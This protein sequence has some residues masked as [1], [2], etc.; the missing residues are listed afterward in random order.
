MFGTARPVLACLRD[1][2]RL[3]GLLPLY[4]L[5]E[6][7]HRKLLP[8]GVGISDHCDCLLEPGLPADAA[9][10][11]L[12]VALKAGR[13]AG[14]TVCDLVDVPAA[15]RLQQATPPAG[16]HG[17]WRQ[18]TPCPVLPVPAG[19]AD[20]AAAVPARQR[21][22]LRM[23][24]HRADRAGG[25]HV[26]YATPA[27]AP[28]LLDDLLRQ[29]ARRWHGVDP[30]VRR[31][32]CRPA[33]P[34]RDRPAAAGGAIRRGA[35]GRLCYAL[36]DRQERLMFY[37]MG[38][39]PAFAALSPGSLLLAAMIDDAIA[40]GCPEVHFLRGD[41]A[42]KYAWGAQDRHNPSCRLEAA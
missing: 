22:K 14:A 18:D 38:F 7:G 11:L 3:A 6:N 33:A 32:R 34:A 28:T 17:E 19:A 29:H 41:E 9:R 12:A 5:D 23:N 4:V 21:R 31:F 36:S 37:M 35:A 8:L 13:S 27:T 2:D 26:E 25:W 15:S 30:A 24:R 1:G 20:A 10:R 40:R 39:D 16:W 42:Y